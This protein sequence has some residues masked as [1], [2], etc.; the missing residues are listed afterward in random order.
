MKRV[1]VVDDDPAILESLADVLSEQYTVL[2]ARNGQEALSLLAAE[3]VDA[4]VLDLMMPIVDGATCLR[5]YRATGGKAPVVLISANTDL[6]R[7]AALLRAD[8]YCDK[9]FRVEALEAKLAALLG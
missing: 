8:A 2:T 7:T 9:P 3:A 4:V 5:R 6:P 1:L